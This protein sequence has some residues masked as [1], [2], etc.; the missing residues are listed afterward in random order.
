M[1]TRLGLSFRVQTSHVDETVD[2]H[3][4]PAE[5]VEQLAL[6]KAKAVAQECD[7]A[8]VIGA[9]TVVVLDGEIL[10]K[11]GD[12]ADA[13]RM[14]NRLQGRNHQVYTGI[15]L[16]EV[17]GQVVRELTD[18]RRTEVKMR[19]LSPQKLEWYVNTGE[20]LD[21][22]GA[23]GIQGYGACLIEKID[24]CY[25]N[26]VGMSISLLDQMLEQMGYS[27][28]KDFHSSGT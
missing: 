2:E 25:F 7:H 28:V 24:G 20:P 5:T 4:S 17:H 3:L 27:L 21:K 22:A 18:H 23:Y 8:L 26:V 15:A 11:P 1:L 13:I 12:Q 9:D 14:L 16:V 10:G 19:E 6:K